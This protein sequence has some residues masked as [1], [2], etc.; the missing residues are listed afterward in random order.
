MA[1]AV[2]KGSRTAICAAESEHGL[3]LGRPMCTAETHYCPILNDPCF[4]ERAESAILLDSL[5]ALHRD[6]DNDGLFEL[7][8]IDAALLE[9]RLATDLAGR[10]ELGRT[11]A[12]RIAPAHLRALPSDFTGSCHS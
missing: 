9:V 5:E 4:L 10:V 8:H 1:I 7:R 2:Q 11:D 12:V 3:P 6:V